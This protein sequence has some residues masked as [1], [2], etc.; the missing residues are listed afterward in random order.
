[1]TRFPRRNDAGPSSVDPTRRSQRDRV[2]AIAAVVGVNVVV[3][4]TVAAAAVGF[5]MSDVMAAALTIGMFSGAAQFAAMSTLAAAGSF[6][7]VVLAAMLINARYILLGASIA[8]TIGGSRVE[9]LLIAPLLI[10][11]IV[12]IAQREPHPSL[13]R[14]TFVWG[15][16]LT[17][18]GWTLGGLGGAFGAARVTDYS[19]IGLDVALPALLLAIVGSSLTTRA[20]VAVACSGATIA[21]I[22]LLAGASTSLA[23][24]LSALGCIGPMLAAERRQSVRG[25]SV[26][27][28]R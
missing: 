25:T 9:R 4:A 19:S 5:G 8:S 12:V 3:G 6:G 13:A 10:D 28:G 26:I 16:G 17:L 22:V 7:V 20:Q 1:M 21:I 24:L 11:P 18:V 2:T 14:R 23:V 27:R 15:G